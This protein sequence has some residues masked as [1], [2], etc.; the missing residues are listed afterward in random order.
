M[1]CKTQAKPVNTV[2]S[3]YS[4]IPHLW[5]Q[6][7][8]DQKYLKK[9]IPEKLQKAKFDFALHWKVFTQNVHCIHNYLYSIY[10]VLNIIN[11]LDMIE[12][13]WEGAHKLYINTMHFIGGT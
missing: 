10:I 2:N 11:S 1:I 7:T 13:V 12:G 5:I 4:Q 6:P 8:V 9:E 3:L